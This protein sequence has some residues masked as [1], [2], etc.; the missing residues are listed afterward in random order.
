M[1]L[2]GIR[3]LLAKELMDTHNL[4]QQQTA[5]KLDV[6]QAAI[7]QYRR[8]LRGSRVK[9]LQ[10]DKEAIT[11]IQSLA[12]KLASNEIDSVAALGEVCMICKIVR[13]QN[14]ICSIHRS[15]MPSLKKCEMCKGPTCQ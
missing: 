3:A 15:S 2:P 14:L 13:K 12:A 5:T 10:K 6:S 8:E 7:S 11:E 1:I 9:I 4:T